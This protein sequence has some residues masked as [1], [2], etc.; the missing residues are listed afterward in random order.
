MHV[1]RNRFVVRTLGIPLAVAGV[2]AA[3]GAGLALGLPGAPVWLVIVL[4]VVVGA[5]VMAIAVVPSALHLSERLERLQTQVDDQ[6]DAD[7]ILRAA[8]LDLESRVERRTRALTDANEDLAHEVDARILMELELE[9]AREAAEAANEAKSSFLASVSHEIRTP[10]NGVVGMIEVL[11]AE[12]RD[13]RTR[14][15]LRVANDASLAL[16]KVL[17]DVLDFSRIE[18]GRLDLTPSPVN[19]REL[20]EAV[21][22]MLGPNASANA[23]RFSTWIDH[24]VPPVIF[25]DGARLRQV[26]VNLVS[27]AVKFC[28]A[29][30]GR[31][32]LVHLLVKAQRPENGVD[33]V[34]FSVIDDGVGIP[35]EVQA[36]LFQPF[37]QVRDDSRPDVAGTGLGLSICKRLVTLMGGRID[38]TSAPDRGTRLRVSLPQNV[39]QTP[40]V[41]DEPVRRLSGYSILV[42]DPFGETVELLRHYLAGSGA[43][44]TGISTAADIIGEALAAARTAAVPGRMILVVGEVLAP[45]GHEALLQALES[46]RALL[47]VRAVLLARG[48]S[49]GAIAS[50]DGV[51]GCSVTPLTEN[52]FLAA[53]DTV[54]GQP[55][56]PPRLPEPRPAL[57]SA[58]QLHPVLVA[59]DSELG[60][61]V[62]HDQLALLG[63]DSETVGDGALALRAWRSGHYSAILADC[64][65][66]QM[67]GFEL[68]TAI[69]EIEAREGRPRTP[70]I[71]FTANALTGEEQRCLSA[72]M[73]GFLAKPAAMRTLQA[74]LSRWLPEIGLASER[75]AARLARQRDAI[76]DNTLYAL[77][78]SDREAIASVLAGFP[79]PAREFADDVIRGLS[80]GDAGLVTAGAHKLKSAARSIGARQLA[81][82]CSLIETAGVNEDWLALRTLVPSL[83]ARLAEVMS[84]LES[85][86]PQTSAVPG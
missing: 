11:H 4:A 79:N 65:M 35:E 41:S 37:V 62:V 36:D 72:G 48:E 39:A 19:V 86:V 42:A 7:L 20:V 53:L 23:L 14:D 18:A 8:T 52:G 61:Q 50:R 9:A 2:A 67:D 12:A 83:D 81:G 38:L 46:D 25:V 44:V 47:G 76:D 43:E 1:P 80:D 6:D 68:T 73:D 82:L 3:V 63:V 32:R 57:G 70:I 33:E 75:T 34:V 58:A 78:G 56:A 51:A 16:L 85:R 5:A 28:G 22:Q 30:A 74:T 64:Q 27:N 49:W 59:E 60:R 13:E 69:R 24:R 66:P 55:A 54:M 21:A 40:E 31:G 10:M 17:D 77:L 71:A 84:A 29:G 26:L 45:L 15:R